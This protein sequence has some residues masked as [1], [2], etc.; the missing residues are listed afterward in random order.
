MFTLLGHD[1]YSIRF[2]VAESFEMRP[3]VRP[4][5]H[6]L[7]FCLCF[8]LANTGCSRDLCASVTTKSGVKSNIKPPP[9]PAY[10]ILDIHTF[11][12]VALVRFSFSIFAAVG[13]F[14]DY[15]HD[16]TLK[17]TPLSRSP[18]PGAVTASASSPYTMRL[19]R[20]S[21]TSPT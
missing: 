13:A 8:G 19:P 10:Q 6:G 2:K 18:R 14:V 15:V 3:F 17:R 20:I 12:E 11:D 5:P 9:P 7:G 21:P 4:D 16:R 1:A